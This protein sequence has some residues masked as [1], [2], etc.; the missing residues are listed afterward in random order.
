[1]KQGEISKPLE[2]ED[3]F[4]IINI[5]ETAVMAPDGQIKRKIRSELVKE[6]D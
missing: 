5:D 3:G 6:S 4:Y 1:M 2:V